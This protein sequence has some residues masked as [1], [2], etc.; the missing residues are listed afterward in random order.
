MYTAICFYS[1]YED[2]NCTNHVLYFPNVLPDELLLFISYVS[3]V[4]QVRSMMQVDRLQEVLC[5]FSDATHEY[6]APTD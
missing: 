3:T 5:L 4:V 1:L 6:E 2:I